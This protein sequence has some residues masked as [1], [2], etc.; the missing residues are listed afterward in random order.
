MLKDAPDYLKSILEI[1][2]DMKVS[3]MRIYK[4]ISKCPDIIKFLEAYADDDNFDKTIAVVRGQLSGYQFGLSILNSLI[5]SRKTLRPFLG[6]H[7]KT[8]KELSGEIIAV[9]GEGDDIS[10]RL[11]NI[12]NANEHL[13]EIKLWFARAGTT[14]ISMDTILPC[15]YSNLFIRLICFF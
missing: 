7:N 12:K 13:C 6:N 10:V 15:K 9:L 1:T 4:V 5:D 3:Y 8:I 14:E 2:G 11:N